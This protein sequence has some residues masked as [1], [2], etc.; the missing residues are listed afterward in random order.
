MEELGIVFGCFDLIVTPEGEYVFLEVNEM[1]QFLFV[2]HWTGMPLLD[3]FCTFLSTGNVDYSW[4]SKQVQVRYQDI[5][6][7]VLALERSYSE[8]HVVVPDAIVKEEE[9]PV[10]EDL[11]L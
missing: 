3:A 7:E 10:E 11:L 5:Q 2:E 9:F 6:Q 1:G 8:A 4:N